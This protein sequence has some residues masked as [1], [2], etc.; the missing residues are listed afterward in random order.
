[1]HVHEW[2][3]SCL[4][5]RRKFLPAVETTLVTI[6]HITHR[7]LSL[8]ILQGDDARGKRY[9]YLSNLGKGVDRRQRGVQLHRKLALHA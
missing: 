4:K 9:G 3:S 7:A 1:M 2:D 5:V 6:P 8:M